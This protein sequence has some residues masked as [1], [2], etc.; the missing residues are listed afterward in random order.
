ML[1]S[2]VTQFIHIYI[3]VTVFIIL[4]IKKQYY[5]YK[6]EEEEENIAELEY[7]FQFYSDNIFYLTVFK[8]LFKNKM[9]TKFVD[10]DKMMEEAFILYDEDRVFRNECYKHGIRRRFIDYMEENKKTK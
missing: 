3:I 1:S 9:L 10:F 6:K 8:I 4:F 5:E 7:K 2:I